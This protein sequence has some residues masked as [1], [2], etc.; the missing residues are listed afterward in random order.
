M[1]RIILS[2]ILCNTLFANAQTTRGI[3]GEANWSKNW[4]NFRP[5]TTDYK[6]ASTLLVGVISQNTTLTKKYIY[7]L[8][9]S[10]YV[11]NGATLTIEPGTIIRGD[12]ATG[13]TLI[14]T[15]GSKIIAQG[16]ETD[17][18]VFTSNKPISERRAGDWGGLI[19]LGESVTNKFTGRLN[20]NLE[21]QY[22]SYGGLHLE[23]DSGVLSYVRIEF[24][25]KKHKDAEALNGL[26]LAGVGSNTKIDN[27]QISFSNDDSFEFYGGSVNFS[28]LISFRA[29]DDD[30][31]FTEGAQSTMTNCVAVRNPYVSD[32]KT[33]RCIEIK[34]YDLVSNADLTKSLTNV[35][36][37]NITLVNEESDN[38]GITNE[39][40]Y[41]K[42]NTFFDISNSVVS[43]FNQCILLDQKIKT[44]F[45][46]LKRIKLEKLMLNN[47]RGYIESEKP[48]YNI[49]LKNWYNANIF[50]VEFS[51]TRHLDLFVES[52]LK[53][54]TNFRI[55][56]DS[57][58]TSSVVT[59]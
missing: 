2:V 15:K 20:F 31:D 9:G 48:E 16:N 13:G 55:K 6:E 45:D 4:S 14:V 38:G 5:K 17:P 41:I 36:A 23:S 30:F 33:S 1:K 47:C 10:V 29:V 50:S 43:G 21:A 51:K 56:P 40:I 22:N 59:N 39:A 7:L 42:E 3:V 8:T 44:E 34:S 19:L 58:L 37:K 24:A 32:P 25:G 27:I 54:M 57:R 26:S 28:N 35:V 18:I 53:R 11:T 12:Y 52:D 46:D 49:Q